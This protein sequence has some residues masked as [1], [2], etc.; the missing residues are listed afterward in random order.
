MYEKWSMRRFRNYTGTTFNSK[1]ISNFM[2]FTTDSTQYEIKRKYTK[3]VSMQVLF[4]VLTIS[5]ILSCL[6]TS[7]ASRNFYLWSKT[8]LF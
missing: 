3:F 7:S 8:S 6:N 2:E 4:Y 1:D 5:F